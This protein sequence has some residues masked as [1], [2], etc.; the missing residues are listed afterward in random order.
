[1][2]N[3]VYTSTRLGAMGKKGIL[4]HDASGYYRAAVGAL[5]YANNAGAWYSE[6]PGRIALFDESGHFQRQIKK[7]V[8]YGE[9]EHPVRERGMT[10]DEWFA[11]LLRIDIDRRSHH[12]KSVELDTEGRDEHGQPCSIIYAAVKPFGPYGPQLKEN[13]DT[14]EMNTYFSIRSLTSDRFTPSGQLVKDMRICAAFDWVTEG[15][16]LVASKWDNVGLEAFQCDFSI[17]DVVTALESPNY[18]Q[19]LESAGINPDDV[20]RQLGITRRQFRNHVSTRWV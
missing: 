4:R 7:G 10:R 20:Y 16:I 17:E 15:G 6:G 3:I 8:S 9:A 18:E 13:L 2:A 11:R 14:P 5:S 1:M 12:L 19:G